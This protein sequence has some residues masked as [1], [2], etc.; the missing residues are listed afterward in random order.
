MFWHGFR[1][2]V[3]D[4]AREI[5]VRVRTIALGVRMA[6]LVAYVLIAAAG[7]LLCRR[8]E[9]GP[10]G[11]SLGL[12]ALLSAFQVLG[13]AYRDHGTFRAIYASPADLA[14][15]VVLLVVGAIA[16]A[17][18][19]RLAFWLMDRPAPRLREG[20]APSEARFLPTPA[21]MALLVV[22]WLPYLVKFLPG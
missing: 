9:V 3:F 4:S 19:V 1:T 10:D 22:A 8:L 20:D 11:W 7:V 16:L 5:I 2:H 17:L 14:L 15:N 21:V 12:G 13:R 18:L 6:D